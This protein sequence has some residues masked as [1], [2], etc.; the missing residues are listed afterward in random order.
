MK[1]AE[2]S[3]PWNSRRGIVLALCLCILWGGVAQTALAK[4]AVDLGEAPVAFGVEAVGLSTSGPIAPTALS[5]DASNRAAVADF[6][7]TTYM[8]SVGVDAGWTGSTASC[9]PGTIT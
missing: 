8:A 1:H 7:Y 4:G 3:Q 5:V 9:D 6:Y 2:S